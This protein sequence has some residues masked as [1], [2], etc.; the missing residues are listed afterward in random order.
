[1]TPKTTAKDFF[2][3]LGSFAGLYVSAISLIVLLVAII[4]RSLPDA[5]NSSYYYYPIEGF[6]TAPIRFAIA[7]LI[8]VFPIYLGVAAYID[9]YLRAHPDRKEVAVRKW[10][11][12]LTVF[13]TAVAVAVDLVVLVNTFLG[14]EITARFI[15]KVL[16]VLVVSG[17]VFGYYWYDLRKTFTSDSPKRTKAIVIAA[18]VVVFGSLVWGFVSVGSPMSARDARFDQR[19][20]DD[21]TSIQW[22]IVNYWQQKARLPQAAAD[23]NDPI[24]S[25]M[26]PVDPETGKAY[27][28]QKTANLSFKL[29]ADFSTKVTAPTTRGYATDGMMSEPSI[30]GGVIAGSWAHDAGTVC[31]DRTIDPELYPLRSGVKGY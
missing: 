16:A 7:C 22:Q 4:N 30:A 19:R 14:G 20:V 13:V 9:R 27:T 28:Y 5:L 25:F 26:V 24:S 12:Y 10:L 17:G 15:L 23:L 2:I 6:Y 29:C 18:C 21:L 3:Y 11:T 1:M 8:I 31:F